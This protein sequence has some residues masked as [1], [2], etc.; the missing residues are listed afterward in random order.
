MGIAEL[1]GSVQLHSDHTRV[2]FAGFPG[3]GMKRLLPKLTQRL[4]PFKEGAFQYDV[5]KFQLPIPQE[6]DNAIS[7]KFLWPR[8][9]QFFKSNDIIV[10][11]TGK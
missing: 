1:S 8:V 2:Q 5:P 9:G 6:E 10:A 7:Q 4:Q 3:I 11:E